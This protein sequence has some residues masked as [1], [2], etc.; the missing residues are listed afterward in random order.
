MSRN[1]LISSWRTRLTNRFLHLREIMN[2]KC[3]NII[4]DLDFNLTGGDVIIE[5]EI[6]DYLKFTISCT[7]VDELIQIQINRYASISLDVENFVEYIHRNIIA[8]EIDRV[9]QFYTQGL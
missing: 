8:P 4:F 6:S 5:L 3:V 1:E 2:T 7:I 9:K